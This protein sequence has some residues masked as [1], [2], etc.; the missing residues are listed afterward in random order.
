MT[1]PRKALIVLDH[2]FTAELADLASG[3]L[4][5]AG[6]S[7]ERTMWKVDSIETQRSE[8][9]RLENEG[10]SDSDTIEPLDKPHDFEV[11][12]TQFAPISAAA[13]ANGSNLK[14]I[15]INRAGT[16]NLAL[17]ASADAGVEIFKVPGR[18]TNAV[19][20]H[21]IG[22]MLAHLRFIATAH[23]E[24]KKGNWQE[25]FQ[26][27]GPRELAEVQV[28]II[29]YGLIGKRVHALL[30]PFGSKIAIFDPFLEQAPE[31]A[32]LVSLD[33][34]VSTSDV[35]TVHVPL[36][37]STRDLIGAREIAMM[38][39]GSIIVNTARA[40]IVNQ[41]ALRN[42]IADG[43]LSG[44]ALDVFDSE[45]IAADDVLVLASSTTITPHLAGT[46][47][48]AFVQGPIW[49]G[50]RMQELTLEG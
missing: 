19:A 38:K 7:V 4:V 26:A 20:E 49:I 37:E 48:Q 6:W 33:E 40:E 9:R 17:Q 39:P 22:L 16:Q 21:T 30:K 24:L 1:K 3:P 36:S 12:I 47:R 10:P 23:S 18:N 41:A 34:L 2:L 25:D 5:A 28:G 8:I 42:A 27:P 11:I 44:A 13:I 46:T 14:L 45:P 31:G 43:S 50:Q 32:E 35:V 29:G 15:A